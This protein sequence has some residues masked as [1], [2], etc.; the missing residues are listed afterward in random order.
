MLS[1]TEGGTGSGTVDLFRLGET[2]GVHVLQGLEGAAVDGARAVLVDRRL[3]L[4]RP[5]PLVLPGRAQMSAVPR[6]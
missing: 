2:R 3:V 5:V 1:S 6:S 4:S